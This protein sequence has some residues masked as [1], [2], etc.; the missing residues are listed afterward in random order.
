MPRDYV[1]KKDIGKSRSEIAKRNRKKTS[2]GKWNDSLFSKG[3]ENGYRRSDRRDK[4]IGQAKT[5]NMDT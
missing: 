2:W 4:E 5:E 1:I 3:I